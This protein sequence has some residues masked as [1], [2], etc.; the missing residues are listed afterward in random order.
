MICVLTMYKIKKPEYYR[1]I[2]KEL[3]VRQNKNIYIEYVPR[4]ERYYCFDS[5]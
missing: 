3:F 5:H 2:G 1:S 4:L